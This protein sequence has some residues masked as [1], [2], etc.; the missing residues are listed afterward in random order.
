VYTLTG[1]CKMAELNSNRKWRYYIFQ[2]PYVPNGFR[3]LKDRQFYTSKYIC[4][5]NNCV[6][7]LV[8]HAFFERKEKEKDYRNLKIILSFC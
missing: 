7:L 5:V 2:F 4:G 8:S 6:C 3:K 1:G